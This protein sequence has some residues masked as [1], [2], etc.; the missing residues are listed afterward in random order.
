MTKRWI[1]AAALMLVVAFQS[2]PQDRPDALVLYRQARYEE[3]VNITLQEIAEN[4]SNFDA[5]TVLGWSLL[6]LG[7]DGDALQ[8][9]DTALGINAGDYRLIQI[10]GEALYFLG[11]NAEAL[12]EFER[13]IEAAPSGEPRIGYAYFLMGNILIRFSEYHGADISL[14]TAVFHNSGV[15]AWWSRLGWAREQAGR[16]EAALEAYERALALNP[17]LNEALRGRDRVQSEL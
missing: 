11:R 16:N 2:F 10:R 8:Y 9:A 1:I 7:R 6:A 13:Y 15:P 14:S 17:S 5:Y 3:S 4:P 12:T